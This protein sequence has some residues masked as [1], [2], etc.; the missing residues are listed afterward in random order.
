MPSTE[1]INEEST[2]KDGHCFQVPAPRATPAAPPSLT[3]LATAYKA[4]LHTG[5]L[6]ALPALLDPHALATV[7]CGSPSCSS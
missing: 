2:P 7:H 1:T 6:P 3:D 4:T 5:A